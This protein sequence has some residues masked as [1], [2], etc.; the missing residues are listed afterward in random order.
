MKLIEEWRVAHKFLSVRLAALAGLVVAYLMEHP[1]HLDALTGMLPD[2]PW[3]TLGSVALGL[4][5]FGVPTGARLVKQ[6]PKNT[7]DAG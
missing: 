5:V 3:R 1:E 2:G 4:I 7:G 6:G